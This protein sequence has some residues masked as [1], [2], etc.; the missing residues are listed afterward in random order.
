[1]RDNTADAFEIY[2]KQINYPTGTKWM[3]TLKVFAN[4]TRD[5]SAA[6]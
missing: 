1:M 2:C 4:A 3:T 5:S 6:Q